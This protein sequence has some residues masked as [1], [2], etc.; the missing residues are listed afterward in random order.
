MEPIKGHTRGTVSLF[1]FLESAHHSAVCT[2]LTSVV[3]SS[4]LMELFAILDGIQSSSCIE[5]LMSYTFTAPT[6]H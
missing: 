6:A 3:V 4:L 1:S 5:T 2:V